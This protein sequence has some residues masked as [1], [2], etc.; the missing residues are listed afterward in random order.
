MTKTK[1]IV[2]DYKVDYFNLM[3]TS[4]MVDLMKTDSYYDFNI[5]R[6]FW[7]MN[8]TKNKEFMF[9]SEMVIDMIY[10]MMTYTGEYYDL[11]LIDLYE[12]NGFNIRDEATIR[13]A[14]I[15]FYDFIERYPDFICEVK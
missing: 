3:I 2:L 11:K 4:N 10:H 1:K 8:E 9:S 6:Y 5:L 7:L 14:R 13:R 12:K 15:Y